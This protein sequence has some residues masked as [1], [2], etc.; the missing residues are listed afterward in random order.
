MDRFLKNEQGLALTLPLL[1]V[2]LALVGVLAVTQIIKN[3]SSVN[4][5]PSVA[6]SVTPSPTPTASPSASP[7]PIPTVTI[8]LTPKVQSGPAATTPPGYGYG[9]ITVN[10]ERGSFPT[11][12]ITL[13]ISSQMVTDTASEGDCEND[14]PTL[15]L[16][17]YV[18][19]NGA[20]AGINGT[21]FCPDTYDDCQ[22]KKNSTD[23]PV[24]NTRLSRWT[25]EKTLFWNSRSIIY[26]DGGGMHFMQD[27]K[28]FGGGLKAGIVNY[29]G[30]LNG[31]QDI[32]SAF[33][34]SAKQSSKGT[35]GGIGFNSTHIHLVIASNVNMA[36]LA[37]IFKTLGDT[38]AL[39]LDGGGSSALWFGGYKVGP[40]RALPNAVL[41]K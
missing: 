24:Y 20:V 29:P 26:Q 16:A 31:G 10:T 12:V 14:C 11:H 18:S 6:I 28:S 4:I 7:S 13:P 27:A 15:A 17:D 5:Q 35:A 33:S 30:L 41:F 1:G 21:Y 19:R 39:N 32:T 36:D 38:Y 2:T 3:K 34:L 22:S 40:G 37:S 25:S 23:F 8:S 9:Y